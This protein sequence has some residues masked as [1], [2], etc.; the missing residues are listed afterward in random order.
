MH[1]CSH[2]RSIAVDAVETRITD[3]QRAGAVAQLISDVVDDGS[4]QF[5]C[6]L[7]LFL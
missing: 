7:N 6:G 1:D 5:D 4:R 2:E 3:R